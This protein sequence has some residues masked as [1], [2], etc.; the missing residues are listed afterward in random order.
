[1]TVRINKSLVRLALGC[2]QPASAEAVSSFIDGSVVGASLSLDAKQVADLLAAWAEGGDVLCVHKRHGLYSLTRQGDAKLSAAERRVRDRTR[3]FLLKE[4][5]RAN[6]AAP[7]DLGIEQADA[8]SAVSHDPAV[9]EDERPIGA[10]G[11]PRRAR[12][13]GRAYWPLLSRQLQVGSSSQPSG[14]FFRFLSFPTVASCIQAAGLEEAHANGVGFAEIALAMGVSPRVLGML[15]HRP[16]RHYR[17]FQVRKASGGV[18]EIR[19][20]RTYMKVTQYFVLDYLLQRLRVHPAATAYSPGCSIKR[21]AE[22]HV[23]KRYVANIDVSDFFGSLRPSLIVAE[24]LAAGLKEGTADFVARVSCYGGGLPQGA[25]TSAALSNIC[26]YSFDSAVYQVAVD[27]GVTYTRYADDIT[28]SSDHQ[29][30]IRHCIDFA[31]RELMRRGLSLNEQKS[32]M[33]GP[34]SRQVVTG[35]V[36][37][38][39]PQPS[40]RERRRLRATL[41]HAIQRPSDFVEQFSHLQGLSAYMLSYGKDGRGVGALSAQYVA[42]AMHAL[43]TFK[44]ATNAGGSRPPVGDVRR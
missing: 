38:D 25:P 40:R 28:F 3:M 12:S 19:S 23:G 37:N 39:H 13:A 43:L 8:S 31:R 30:A 26:M 36:V 22:H 4:L 35:L 32:R 21:N 5:R 29:A 27:H 2:I 41:H 42:S 16:E 20:P 17:A 9:Q 24:L 11:S 14:T 6:V 18:R 44:E 1:M 33:F 15:A 7:E 10:A 34:A